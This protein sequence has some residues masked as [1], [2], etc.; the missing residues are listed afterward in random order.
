MIIFLSFKM[1]HVERK[2]VD[3]WRSYQF[4]F[5]IASPKSL[6]W[7]LDL[8]ASPQVKIFPSKAAKTVK[9]RSTNPGYN[10]ITVVIMR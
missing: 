3:I 9:F 6:E 1:S 4:V 7:L 10:Q 2:F 8:S 5:R